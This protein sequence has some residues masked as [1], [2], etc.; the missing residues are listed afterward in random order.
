MGKKRRNALQNLINRRTALAV[1]LA[2]GL[3][4][5]TAAAQDTRQA[6]AGD[7]VIEQI[8]QRGSLIVGLATFVPWAMLDKSGELIGFEIDVA[9]KLAADLGVEVEFVPTAWDGIIP[10]LIAGNFDV[11]ISGM[12]VTPQRNLTVN[13]SDPYAFSGLRVVVA[14]KHEGTITSLE[15]MDRA[16]FT[17]ALRR[18]ATPVAFAQSAL[19]NARLLQ[20]DEDGAS[21]QEV[22]NGN[23]DATIASEP[24]PSRYAAE[25]P[26]QLYIPIDDLFN[27]TAEAFA[28]RKGDPDALNFFNNWIAI[29]WRNGFLEE[30]HDYWFRTQEWADQLPN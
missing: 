2:A 30:R 4:A 16:D 24:S 29:N 15:D 8:K 10:A 3:V 9:T 20:F 18:G 19:P 26:D 5:G 28:L 14:R 1:A 7:S 6:V 17:L 23:A 11:I 25:Y 12:S 22:L 21:L 27:V 13:F